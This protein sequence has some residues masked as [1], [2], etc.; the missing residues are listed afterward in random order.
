MAVT[1]P[2]WGTAQRS[3]PTR[4]RRSASS[5]STAQRSG[6][7][8][9]NA[10]RS[11]VQRSAA[12]RSTAQR[13]SERRD[14]FSSSSRSASAVRTLPRSSRAAQQ[15]RLRARASSAGTRQGGKARYAVF[16]VLGIVVAA[17]VLLVPGLSAEAS[18]M[19]SET[20]ATSVVTVNP[21][22]SLWSV[23]SRSMP[24]VDTRSAVIELRK[25]NNLRGSDL[26]VGQQLVV[27]N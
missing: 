14:S 25:A 3:A 20:P 12:L 23:A 13:G 15:E 18:H 19:H 11:N 2:A 9:S 7:H 17:L 6:A 5:R 4:E 8:R 26:V 16:A 27:P 22:D 21:G 10:Q 1:V 24:D